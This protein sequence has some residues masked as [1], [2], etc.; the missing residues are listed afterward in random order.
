M[1]KNFKAVE[2]KYN[3][4]RSTIFQSQNVRNE[5]CNLKLETYHY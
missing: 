5:K 4:H 1:I 3:A 2:S